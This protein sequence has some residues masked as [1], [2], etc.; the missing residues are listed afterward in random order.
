M[1]ITRR[2]KIAFQFKI[3]FIDMKWFRRVNCNKT[4][5]DRNAI[6]LHFLGYDLVIVKIAKYITNLAFS[7]KFR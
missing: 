7:H 1:N 4:D 2:A 3:Y 5:L 6:Q